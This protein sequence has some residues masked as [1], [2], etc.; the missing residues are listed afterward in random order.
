M[1]VNLEM[2]QTQPEDDLPICPKCGNVMKLVDLR[3]EFDE[4]AIQY[5][6]EDIPYEIVCCGL[7]L[8]IKNDEEAR[9]VVESLKQFHRT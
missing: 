6:D 4:A 8:Y 5:T 1:E 7:R 2:N 3:S 9:R